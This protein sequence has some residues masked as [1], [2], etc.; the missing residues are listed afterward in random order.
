LRFKSGFCSDDLDNAMISIETN[1]SRMI[2]SRSLQRSQHEIAQAME[3]LAT[4]KQ[5]NRA[6]DNPAG[7]IA[8]TG[9]AQDQARLNKK[10]ERLELEDKRLGAIEG[11]QS[12]VGDLLLELSSVVV[13]SANTAGTSKGEREAMQIQAQSVMQT[14][15]YLAD[16]T[17]FNGDHLLD[18][19]RSKSLGRVTRD[20]Q[21][22]DGTTKQV[23]YSLADIASGKLNL[24]DGDHELAQQVV[25]AAVADIATK[26]AG[27]GIRSNEIHSEIRVSMTE[28]ENVTA[29][30]SLIEDTD[31]AAETAKLVRAQVL[32]QAGIYTAQLADQVNSDSALKLLSAIKAFK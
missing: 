1:L 5:I 2:A 4:G 12:V 11:A 8:V 26:R 9:F 16:T 21:Q 28:Y 20:E 32:Q 24:V 13:S 10:V 25:D 30:R 14:I 19:Q 27:I 17:V 29:A 15:D 18:G 6:S 22:P 23:T 7:L 3:R 31:Y